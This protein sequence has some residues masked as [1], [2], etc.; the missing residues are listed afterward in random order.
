MRLT[1]QDKSQVKS[2]FIQMLND[3][4]FKQDFIVDIQKNRIYSYELFFSICMEMSHALDEYQGEEVVASL[5]NSA[6]L[7]ALYFATL[8][9]NKV[10]AVIDPK[11]G[12]EEQQEI[13]SQHQGCLLIINDQTDIFNAFRKE[14]SD[15]GIKQSVIANLELKDF[16][17]DFLITYTSGTT[18]LTKGVLHSFYNLLSTAYALGDKIKIKPGGTYLHVMPMT[19]MAGILNSIFFPF[20]FK[21][22]IVI[23]PRFSVKAA[24]RFWETMTAYDVSVLWL[25]PAM[26]MMID[27]VD[28]TDIGEAYCRGHNVIFLIGTA[29][30]TRNV[31]INFENRYHTKLLASYG[32]SET[33][34]VSVETMNSNNSDD[35]VG[36]LLD[37][38]EISFGDD[39]E[40]R[41]KVPWMFKGYTNVPTDPYFDGKFYLS[42]DIAEYSDTLKITGR[43]K[44]LIVKGGMNVSPALIENEI[45]KNKNV[46]EC[47]VYGK[48]ENDDE[49]LTC[50]SY[51]LKDENQNADDI[52]K[53]LARGVLD[54][55]GINYRIDRFYRLQSLPRNVNGKI[56]KERLKRNENV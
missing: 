26:L 35:N 3:L 40:L 8:F 31:R 44:D 18:G 15:M 52:E 28:R 56:D 22:K 46:L 1:M 4:N 2:R 41:I 47:A 34:F 49:E 51:V 33:L 23:G 20:V 54:K 55:L 29:A 9:S 7:A 11:K 17:Q 10:I 39:K 36:E 38:V 6:E 53:K 24:I 50:C 48:V 12:I 45:L 16:S 37:G 5:E 19:Y 13:I 21:Q 25:S 42:G 14:Q 27:K 30:L 32:L 43:K